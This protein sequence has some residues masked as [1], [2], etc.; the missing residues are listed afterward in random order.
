MADASS[1]SGMGAAAVSAG[2]QGLAGY[3]QA[4]YQAEIERNKRI[5][6]AQQSQMNQVGDYGKNQQQMLQQLMQGS[7]AALLRG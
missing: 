3:L 1:G 4:M 5:Q 2:A 7:Q 6:E